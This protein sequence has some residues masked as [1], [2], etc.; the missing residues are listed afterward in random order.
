MVQTVAS[1]A[2]LA[3]PWRECVQGF[4]LRYPNPQA[5]HV[6]SVD[7]IARRIEERAPPEPGPLPRLVLCTSRLILKSGSLPSWVPR[8]IIQHTT[9]W[10]LEDSEVDLSADTPRVMSIWTRNLDH[11]SV[12]AVTEALTL[13]DDGP[14][15]RMHIEADVR[16]GVSFRLLR[17]RIEKFGHKRYLSHMESSRHG[18][19]WA[20]MRIAP[21]L[22]H[23]PQP[24]APVPYRQRLLHALRPPFLDGYP[25]TPWQWLKKQ[26]R[27]LRD[28]FCQRP[29]DT[30]T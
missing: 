3:F 9:S 15:T 16:S 21:H 4:F 23:N 22:V 1:D 30:Q 25:L 2:Q 11:T 12:L 7:V 29:T 8:N 13:R 24:Q 14:S 6:L 18:L 17:R 26:G 10:V 28:K 19:I 20:I 5:S 27:R